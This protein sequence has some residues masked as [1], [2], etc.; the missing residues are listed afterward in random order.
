M[1]ELPLDLPHFGLR[2]HGHDADRRIQVADISPDL[3]PETT[4]RPIHDDA[5]G[6]DL[7]DSGPGPARITAQIV[8][9]DAERTASAATIVRF[10]VFHDDATGHVRAEAAPVQAQRCDIIFGRTAG[11]ASGVG[12]TPVAQR[13][14]RAPD[15]GRT[16]EYPVSIRC[17]G[18]DAMA[19]PVN[20]VKNLGVEPRNVNRP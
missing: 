20:G 17:V 14:P 9:D 10:E 16:V 15:H 7:L 4:A 19:V 2:I 12:S 11:R 6:L 18:V 5:G 1:L 13:V 3:L 8:H